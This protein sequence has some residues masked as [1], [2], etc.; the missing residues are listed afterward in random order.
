MVGTEIRGKR[1]RMLISSRFY[2]PYNSTP[3][4]EH[5]L[6]IRIV[7][8]PIRVDFGTASL[9]SSRESRA[10]LAELLPSLGTNRK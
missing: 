4:R 8:A 3:E 6:E 7:L 5:R 1:E 10:Q 2:I 9:T